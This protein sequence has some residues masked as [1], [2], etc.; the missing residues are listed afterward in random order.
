[1]LQRLGVVIS[2]AWDNTGALDF[3]NTL[4]SRKLGNGKK[5]TVILSG[6][7]HIAIDW[8]LMTSDTVTVFHP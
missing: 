1:M 8:N 7:K 4:F 2:A 6:T 3:L 5:P